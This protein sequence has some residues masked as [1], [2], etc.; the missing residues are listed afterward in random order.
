MK[1]T[2][3]KDKNGKEIFYGNLLKCDYGYTIAVVEIDGEPYGKLI[4]PKNHP[5]A[6]IPYALN[7]E[8]SVVWA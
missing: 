5:C 2:N 7:P 4:V 8:I 1:T 3:K 6:N